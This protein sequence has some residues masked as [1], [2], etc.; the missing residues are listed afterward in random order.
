MTKK[1]EKERYIKNKKKK[2]RK[3]EGKREREPIF[4]SK[5][6]PAMLHSVLLKAAHACKQSRGCSSSFPSLCYSTPIGTSSHTQRETNLA[7]LIIEHHANRS[8]LHRTGF[9]HSR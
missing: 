2:N 7:S 9:P 5:L 4:T 8:S 6:R 1:S 3:E